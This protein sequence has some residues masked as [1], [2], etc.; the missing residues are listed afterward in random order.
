VLGS[1]VLW[2]VGNVG[3]VAGRLGDVYGV[4]LGAVGLLTTTMFLTHLAAQLPAG[5]A[6][7]RIGARTVALFAA[8]IILGGNIL[9][10]VDDAYG[11]A[12]GG[13][14]VVGIGTGAAFVASLDLVRAGGGGPLAQGLFG[15]ITTAAGGVTLMTLPALETV[16]G[17]RAAYWTAAAF[18]GIA[19]APILASRA[20]HAVASARGGLLADAQLVPLAVVHA[21][22]FGLNVIAAAWVVTLLQHQGASTSLAGVTGGTV[23]LFGIVSRPLGGPIVARG[24]HRTVTSASLVALAL[25]GALMAT[26]ISPWLSAIGA[27]LIGVAAGLPWVGLYHSAQRLRPDGPAAATAFVNATASLAIVVGT[28]LVGV[29]FDELPG[30]GALGFAALGGFALAA[31][32][33]WQRARPA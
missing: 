22:T 31:L 8:A 24:L 12:L 14:A 21:A 9:L 19:V 27:M 3:A 2:N 5:L 20:T 4:S 11:L 1:A 32:V 7:D 10:L 6:A 18:I 30:D 28:P 26:G 25:A 17:W 23:L 16:A 33:V 13:R 29:T 15:G